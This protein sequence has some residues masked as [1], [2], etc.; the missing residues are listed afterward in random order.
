MKEKKPWTVEYRPPACKV[1]SQA[2]TP[3][4]Q[5]SIGQAKLLMSVF[6]A[7]SREI[8]AVDAVCSGG[9]V[10]INNSKVYLRKVSSA[11]TLKAIGVSQTVAKSLTDG[12]GTVCSSLP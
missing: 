8:L 10:L 1:V 9:A 4:R 7:F 5:I 6:K 12:R 3:D 2:T 11:S